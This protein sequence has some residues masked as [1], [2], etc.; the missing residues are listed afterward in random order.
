M[1]M[2]STQLAFGSFL[3]VFLPSVWAAEEPAAMTNEE[4]MAYLKERGAEFLEADTKWRSVAQTYDLFKYCPGYCMQIRPD[5][6]IRDEDLAKVKYLTTTHGIQLAGS[7]QSELDFNVTP[8]GLKHLGD[9]KNIVAIS[10]APDYATKQRFEP[11]LAELAN[12]EYLALLHDM[13]G[14]SA[15]WDANKSITK[16]TFARMKHLKCLVVWRVD[17]DVLAELPESIETLI[18]TGSDTLSGQ[19]FGRLPKL[20][21][22][23]VSIM[24]N[25]WEDLRSNLKKMG[26]LKELTVHIWASMVTPVLA[27]RL[28]KDL[29]KAL[30]NTKI[31]VDDNF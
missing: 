6:S 5:S 10:I 3:M 15:R 31:L 20:T 22:L 18:V 26:Q 27:N 12:L 17:D 14:R 2:S 1:K 21:K 23:E 19:Y 13:R 29:E 24:P 28:Q 30:P 9:A 7:V 11:A 8:A 25:A 16:T 4:A